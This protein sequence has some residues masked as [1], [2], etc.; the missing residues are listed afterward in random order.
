MQGLMMDYQLNVP[1]IMQR[2]ER[3]VGQLVKMFVNS[4]AD[5]KRRDSQDA[6]KFIEEEIREHEAKLVASENQLRDFKL[7]NFG[8]TRHGRVV[9]YDYDEICPLTECNFRRIPEPRDE[10]EEM[11]GTPWYTRPERSNFE[12]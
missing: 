4:G 9:F 1:A 8:V 2:A 3:L 7:K 6:R 12:P 5:N 11:A 10:A